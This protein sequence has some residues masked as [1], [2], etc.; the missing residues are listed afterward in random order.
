[1]K[2]FSTK[3]ER[4]R[5]FEYLMRF[6][7]YLR[8]FKGLLSLALLLVPLVSVFQLVQP[9]LIKRGI[10]VNIANKDIAGLQY[11]A[12]LF[13]LC[14]LLELICRATQSY[15]FQS[16][17][18]RSVT[19]VR[20]DLFRH[21]LKQSSSYFDKTPVGRLT[22][23][24]TS[25]IEALNETLSSGL[26]TLL[27]DILTLVGIVSLM[28]YLSVKLTIV[29]LV[30]VP[31]LFLIVNYF[32]SRLRVY[33]NDIRSALA[34]VNA[35]LQEQLDGYVI[36]QLFERERFN[37]QRFTEVNEEY[38]QANLNSIKFDSLLYSVIEAISTIVIAL[39]LWYGFGELLDETITL[40]LLVA[41]IDYIRKFFLPLRELSS[42]FAI[43]QAALA[44]LEKIFDAFNLNHIVPE[45]S[46]NPPEHTGAISFEGVSFSYPGHEN[47][48]VL[49]DVSFHIQP[50]EVVAVV[51][52]TGSGKSTLTSLLT[53]LYT[54]YTGSI[55][56]DGVELSELS[57]QALRE[58]V[59]I[60]LQDVSLFSKDIFFNITLGNPNISPE[61]V[62]KAAEMVQAAS[63][64]ERLP[65]DFHYELQ[66][67]GSNLSSGQAQ[68]ISFARALAQDSPLIILDEATASVDSMSERTI[69][70]AIEEILKRKTVLVIAHRLSTIKSA[71]RILAMRDGQVVETGT[72]QQLIEQGGFYAKLFQMQYAHL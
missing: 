14:V 24:V 47:K 13:G 49:K 23:R 8:N 56:I 5:D 3:E 2:I 58:R 59:S 72:H 37:Y 38:K 27:T 43:L 10:D 62:K 35:Y 66:N 32:K 45:G 18:I 60:V 30:A 61:N 21:I 42:K 26:I 40:G 19:E 16:I 6:W 20:D 15:L 54:G 64:I 41:F 4:R 51:G 65:G 67:K 28:F 53:R 17:G 63:F 11:T 39:M 9:L 29:T 31:V 25:D 50:G 33:Y 7:T 48:P 46:K 57:N 52:P 44:A 71:D 22:T 36:V 55:C 34:K 1:M 69:Q 70:D 12:L 68:L